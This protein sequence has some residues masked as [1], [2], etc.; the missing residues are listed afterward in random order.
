MDQTTG[1]VLF[2]TP[3]AP[4]APAG[5]TPRLIHIPNFN[6]DAAIEQA[7][8]NGGAIAGA[9]VAAG[10]TGLLTAGISLFRGAL[11]GAQTTYAN[12]QA[13]QPQAQP[14]NAQVVQ[15]NGYN[16]QIAGPRS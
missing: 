16:L 15:A 10:I 11:L 6:N 7:C 14:T 12:G 5:N 9:A 13:H 2:N 1:Q 4:V 8:I 3:Q